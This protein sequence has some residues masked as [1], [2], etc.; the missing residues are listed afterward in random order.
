VAV[1]VATPTYLQADLYD[2]CYLADVSM[3]GT[4]DSMALYGVENA[5][6]QVGS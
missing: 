5:K 2:T 4:H 3:P 1:H 6:C